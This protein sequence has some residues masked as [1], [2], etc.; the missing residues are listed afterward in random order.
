[1][2][3]LNTH[4]PLSWPTNAEASKDSAPPPV[5]TTL[6]TPARQVHSSN[7][8][9]PGKHEK[10]RQSRKTFNTALKTIIPG[11]EKLRDR[12]IRIM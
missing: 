4:Y 1:M 12:L 10:R 8:L 7:A 11:D 2:V 6:E 3:T 9:I 5:P